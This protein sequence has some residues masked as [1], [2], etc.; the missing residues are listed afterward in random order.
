M[1]NQDLVDD[2]VKGRFVLFLG[3]GASKSAKLSEAND[4]I[5][6]WW[7][8]LNFCNEKVD[9][10][11]LKKII[12]DQLKSNDYLMAAELLKNSLNEQW[13]TLIQKEFSKRG[14][15][16][17][18]H[19]SLLKLNPR[20][21]VTTNFDKL[22]ENFWEGFN[23][24]VITKVD[25][26]VFKIFRDEEKYLLKIHGSVDDPSDVVFDKSSFQKNAFSNY[27]YNDFLSTL[28]LTHTFIFLGVSMNDPAINMVVENYAFRYPQNRPHYIFQSGDREPEIEN[29]WR[30]I[31]KLYVVRYSGD[32]DHSGLPVM[33]EKLVEQ[34]E[35]RRRILKVESL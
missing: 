24:N 5:K 19:K 23:P 14:V 1:F 17:R 21:V 28:L 26:G 2:V 8:F 6:D 7:E 3:A 34:V 22:I 32:N 29:I 18:L 16:S 31:R 27:F 12:N 10:A 11:R 33:I 4:I 20:I 13:P 25:G 30:R 35:A 9:D 15:E